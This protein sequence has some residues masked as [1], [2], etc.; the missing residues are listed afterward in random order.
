MTIIGQTEE[1][2]TKRKEK[3]K[4]ENMGWW[5]RKEQSQFFLPW[6][7][8]S[9][10]S[11]RGNGLF[12]QLTRSQDVEPPTNRWVSIVSVLA[13]IDKTKLYL[14]YLLQPQTAVYNTV[15]KIKKYISGASVAVV[16]SMKMYY[17]CDTSNFSPQQLLL[18]LWVFNCGPLLCIV[19]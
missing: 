19:L 5:D 17:P 12:I 16:T 13:H 18:V 15:V 10:Q 7:C 6:W 14:N 1:S 9:N 11:W 2:E 4:K 8:I 3:K